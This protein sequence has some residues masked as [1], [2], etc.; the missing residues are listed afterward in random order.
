[1][2]VHVAETRTELGQLAAHDI[3]AALRSALR[4]KPQVRIIFAAA[5]SQSQSLP[6][7]CASRASTGRASPPSTWMN[8]SAWPPTLRSVSAHGSGA[9]FF[10]MSPWPLRIS[11]IPAMIPRQ[12]ATLMRRCCKRPPLIS[13]C[14]A[15]VP[16]AILPSTIRQ[17]TST[18]RAPSRSS[19]ST[20]CAASSRFLTVAFQRSRRFLGAPLR[21]GAHAACRRGT[22][23]LCARLA[24]EPGGRGHASVADQWR[25]PCHRPAHAST[26]YCISRSRIQFFAKQ[27]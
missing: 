21:H 7:C 8:I 2:E 13:C 26:V 4:E 25:L 3:A 11:S 9:S 22:V 12:P 16:T 14:S 18:T 17:P 27:P 1:M 6:L 23:L 5:P 15:S 19:N 10:I 24:Q 20:R